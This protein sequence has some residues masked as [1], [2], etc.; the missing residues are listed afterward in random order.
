V[1]ESIIVPLGGWLS[2]GGTVCEVIF[3]SLR[4]VITYFFFL[5]TIIIV[6]NLFKS[7]LYV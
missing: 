3:L 2:Y 7:N 4:G 6:W 5:T 1:Y